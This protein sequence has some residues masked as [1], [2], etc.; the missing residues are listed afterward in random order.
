MNKALSDY[1]EKGLSAYWVKVDLGDK[2]VWFRF[3]AGYFRTKEEAEKYIR[4]RN[5]QGASPGITKYA[6]LIGI[7]GSDKEVEDQKRAL[8]SA[9]FYPYVIKAS[10]GKSL[11]YSGA[12][13]RKEYAEK[14]R[15][16]L[17]FEGYPERSRRAV[18]EVMSDED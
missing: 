4:D 17:G 18:E 7:Y 1:Q 5:I 3:F 12:F 14:E 15:S 10:D 13:D 6:N 2:G 11:L 16:A 8:V 9:G